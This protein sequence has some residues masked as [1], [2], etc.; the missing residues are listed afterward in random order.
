MQA[1][2]KN[3]EVSPAK[4]K[5]VPTS[6]SATPAIHPP[7]TITTKAPSTAEKLEASKEGIESLS[8][9]RPRREIQLPPPPVLRFTPT[10][11]AKLQYFCHAGETEIGG[12]GITPSWDLLLVEDFVTV[13]QRTSMVTVAFDDEAVADF[14]E[15]QAMEG[16]KPE[17]FGRIWL[18][19]HPGDSAAP[20][21]T[22]EETFARVFGPCDWAVMF[23]LAKGGQ[24]YARLR[25]N[26]GPGGQLLIPVAVD[27][28]QPF[29]A[30]DHAAWEDEY[31][32][33]VWPLTAAKGSPRAEMGLDF[34]DPWLEEM[35][36]QRERKIDEE[37]AFD[38]GHFTDE[39]LAQAW[40][41]S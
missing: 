4:P 1:T 8:P 34:G 40:R 41:H 33:N 9:R 15:D 14:F 36:L 25:F 31:D 38:L 2:T 20:S 11:W 28:Q 32:R 26:A 6:P 10:A 12:F 5:E 24:T 19:T 13:R 18:H 21:S 39:E 30:S 35:A 7:E 22:D 17:Q 23:I 16:R 37:I 27:Y 3:P 29:E